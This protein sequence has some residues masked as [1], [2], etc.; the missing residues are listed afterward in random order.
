M[1]LVFFAKLN[2][3]WAPFGWNAI[4]ETAPSP[5]TAMGPPLPLSWSGGTASK[6]CRKKATNPLCVLQKGP[7]PT[8]LLSPINIWPTPAPAQFPPLLV[9]K[10]VSSNA[11]RGCEPFNRV[12]EKQTDY[13]ELK[14]SLWQFITFTGRWWR[15]F[16]LRNSKILTAKNL[17]CLASLYQE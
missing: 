1:K 2:F 3:F 11:G 12:C 10:S 16:F 14:F 7:G 4:S 13:Q 6:L 15:G 8:P 9:Q 5:P 17:G